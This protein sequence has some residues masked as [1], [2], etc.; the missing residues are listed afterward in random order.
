MTSPTA[1]R[2]KT[3]LY[4]N[5]PL[6]LLSDTGPVDASELL[7]CELGPKVKARTLTISENET[8]SIVVSGTAP[9]DIRLLRMA[10]QLSSVI[11]RTPHPYQPY[12]KNP[13]YLL[14]Y[15]TETLECGHELVFYPH[16]DPLI[17]RRRSCLECAALP[18]K[19]P[20][21][22]VPAKRRAA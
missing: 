13:Q 6:Y 4:H 11:L 5:F 7:L 10:R 22:S 19:K 15:V 16:A 8:T 12:P 17:A 14:C 3:A 18:E 21:Q 9:D 2:Q 1:P 20:V